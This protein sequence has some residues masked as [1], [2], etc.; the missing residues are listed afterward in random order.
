MKKAI[1]SISDR[2]PH[3]VKMIRDYV[4]FEEVTDIEY[5]NGRAEMGIGVSKVMRKE[6]LWVSQWA[7]ELGELGVWLSQYRCWQW[8]ANNNEDL[9]VFED[10]AV[11]TPHF[12]EI[13]DEFYP[14][15]PDDYDFIAWFVPDNQQQDYSYRIQYDT[16]GVPL[17][18]IHS[19]DDGYEYDYGAKDMARVYQGYSC[20]CV[21]YSPKGA[22]KFID[23]V[24]TRGIYTPVDCF[25]YLAAHRGAVDGYAPKPYGPRPVIVDWNAPTEVHGTGF[26]EGALKR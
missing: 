16:E 18:V 8:C 12:K 13:Y 5:V 26:Y 20:V 22:Q 6:E 1:I 21:Q 14:Q 15:V 10:D 19:G 3:Y 7:P 4:P 17:P 9:I 25:L 2:T 11:P 24:K 23:I